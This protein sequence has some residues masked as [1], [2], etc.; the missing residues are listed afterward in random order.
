MVYRH[1]GPW[2]LRTPASSAEVSGHFGTT[3][4]KIVLHLRSSELLRLNAITVDVWSRLNSSCETCFFRSPSVLAV[5]C[6]SQPGQQG[7]YCGQPP[8]LTSLFHAQ[9]LNLV[10]VRSESPLRSSGINFRPISGKHQHWPLSKNILRHSYSANTMALSL[11]NNNTAMYFIVLLLFLILICFTTYT[12]LF[13]HLVLFYCMY[14]HDWLA[15]L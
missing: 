3:S 11:N 7:A 1:F 8:R 5:A 6:R 14:V 12:V 9:D 2:T 10:N 15:L 13:Y 4:W